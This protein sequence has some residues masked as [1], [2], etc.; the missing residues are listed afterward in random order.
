[1]QVGV[2][3]M[4]LLAIWAGKAWPQEAGASRPLTL[5]HTNDWHGT[6]A[7]TPALWMG[8]ADPP[9]VGGPGLL[10]TLLRQRKF[11]TLAGGGRYLLVD[12]GDRFQGAPVVNLSRGRLMTELYNLLGYTLVALGNHDFDYDL[13]GLRAAQQGARFPLLCTNLR[14]ATASASLWRASAIAP[15]G[16]W[17]VGF[18]A[19]MTED[20]P[21][22]TFPRNIDGVRLE[23][24]IPALRREVARL[25]EKGCDL[26][27]LLS[28]CGHP[29][30]LLLAVAVPGL[31]VILGGHSQDQLDQPRQINGVWIVQT[32]GYGS[33]LGEMT[34]YSGPGGKGIG[35]LE[36][37][38]HLLEAGRLRSDPAVDELFASATA[39]LRSVTE[40][41]A[42]TLP[43]PLLRNA[44]GRPSFAAVIARAVARQSGVPIGVFHCGGVRSDLPA[45]PLTIGQ[46]LTAL[47]FDHVVVTGELS[48]ADL[49]AAFH[50]GTSLGSLAWAGLEQDP[51]GQIRLESGAALEPSQR[52]RVA[53]NDFLAQGGDGFVEF[54]RATGARDPS[55]LV[56]EAFLA[57]LAAGL[58]APPHP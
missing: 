43:E 10:A 8:V 2:A 41:S 40:R 54:T 14:L 56:R 33:H 38:S 53:F 30:D 16:G 13:A 46:V 15:I 22:I 58:P 52:Y 5:F 23:P 17:R 4:M 51:T 45:G 18:V 57:Y 28:H 50:R 55:G 37:R 36:Y 11:A 29:Y 34:I 19:A 47:P 42:G 31:D 12:A 39:A 25:R 35:R 24:V 49:A 32:R 44:N 21:R 1:M 26:V 48:G 20:L 27:V 9:L 6:I 3:A 7:P